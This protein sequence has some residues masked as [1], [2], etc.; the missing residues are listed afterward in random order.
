MQLIKSKREQH[1]FF[2][3]Q[4]KKNLHTRKYE[5]SQTFRQSYHGQRVI[6]VQTVPL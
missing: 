2:V 6:T 4:D 5:Q 3:A 1:L